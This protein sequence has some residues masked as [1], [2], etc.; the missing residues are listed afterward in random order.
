MDGKGAFRSPIS[1]RSA[2][3]LGAAGVLAS[4][5]ELLEQLAWKPQRLAMAANP[6]NEIQ[7][8]IGAFIPPA[9]SVN[10]VQVRFATVF[11][12]FQPVR[13]S[14]NP[15]GIDQ[16]ILTGA[17]HTIEDFYDFSPSGIFMFVSYGVPYFNR[18]PGGLN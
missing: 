13:L 3:K 12:V 7:F 5:M 11:T 6:P 15:D 9:F 4:Q 8:D 17:L 1:R 16:Q 2:L 10:G 14:R 18:L